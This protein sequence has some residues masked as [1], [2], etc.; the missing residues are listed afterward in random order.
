MIVDTDV[1]VWFMRGNEKALD[2]INS[3]G[4]FSI[5]IVSYIELVQGMRNKQELR[6]LKLFLKEEQVRTL[7]I[8][9]AVSM[10]AVYYMEEFALSHKLVLA[11]A[12]IAATVSDRGDQLLTGN[13]KH[14]EF[15]SDCPLAVFK[16]R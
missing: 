12:L 2:V 1:M 11:D 4:S 7:P 3:L 13:T 15:I 14:Y 5:S 8:S 10:R 6:E 9:E 16:P